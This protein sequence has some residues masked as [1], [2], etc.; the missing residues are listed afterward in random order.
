MT[1][2]IGNVD[3]NAAGPGSTTSAASI[4][5]AKTAAEGNWANA[6]PTI[7]AAMAAVADDLP[8][9]NHAG[10]IVISQGT[11]EPLV[12][13]RF[14]TTAP[15]TGLTGDP[16]DGTSTINMTDT[17]GVREGH[18]VQGTGI[19]ADTVVTNVTT[20]TSITVNTTVTGGTGVAL[21]FDYYQV[22][23]GGQWYNGNDSNPSALMGS[24]ED[25][26]SGDVIIKT[27][28]ML[29]REVYDGRIAWNVDHM[30][31]LGLTMTQVDNSRDGL[32]A[33]T[34]EDSVVLNNDIQS[35]GHCI[36]LTGCEDSFICGNKCTG[37]YAGASSAI[38]LSHT[39]RDDGIISYNHVV[40]AGDP[41]NPG[42][43]HHFGI[44]VDGADGAHVYGNKVERANG[45]GIAVRN[46]AGTTANSLLGV[47]V[48]GNSV[49][50][51]KDTENSTGYPFAYTSSDV[52][53]F[54]ANFFD[55][56]VYQNATGFSTDTGWSGGSEAENLDSLMG[57]AFNKVAGSGSS[58]SGLVVSLIA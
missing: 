23:G 40:D 19:P 46:G 5:A 7:E 53:D 16:Q 9:N 8:G 47:R 1:I 37:G 52:V 26:R 57:Q 44:Q 12:E 34:A 42:N 10:W 15:V 13:L 54:E 28:S 33:S 50:E 27:S 25:G 48:Y 21:T 14:L 51:S 43:N 6:F 4:S 38:K 11:Y 20:N 49:T 2:Y 32:Y 24:W 31:I 17:T 35:A 36:L 56:A 3:V 22:S 55:K 41:N 18:Y 39:G 29:E 58:D 30:H 45:T